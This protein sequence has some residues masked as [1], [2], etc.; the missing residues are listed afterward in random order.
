MK[1]KFASGAK[2]LILE[3]CLQVVH[4]IEDLG[5]MAYLKRYI[6]AFDAFL[7]IEN[8]NGRR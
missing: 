1:L 6:C 8:E 5:N 2:K 3:S 4:F 7:H